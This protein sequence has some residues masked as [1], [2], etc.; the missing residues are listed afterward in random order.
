MPA[1]SQTG[2]GADN[3]KSSSRGNAWEKEKA[4]LLA[5]IADLQALIDLERERNDDLQNQ[6]AG[7]HARP[8]SRG[9]PALS[10]EWLERYRWPA[11]AMLAA[12][13]LAI[14]AQFVWIASL[15]SEMAEQRI[16]FE[17][18][19][20]EQQKALDEANRQAVQANARADQLAGELAAL[21]A[22]QKAAAA[23]VTKPA[24][25]TPRNGTKTSTSK[26]R[27]R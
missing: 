18:R 12:I 17:T 22:K 14:I 15:R 1:P 27:T 24:A 6:L 21:Q 11:V 13:V 26:P 4:E 2:A 9:L 7:Q 23:R 19:A 10:A 5:D 25:T 8:P 3:P 20:A 16:A